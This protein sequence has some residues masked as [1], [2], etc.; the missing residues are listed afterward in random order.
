MPGIVNVVPARRQRAPASPEG[1]REA[2]WR[3]NRRLSRRFRLHSSPLTI[4]SPKRK[5]CRGSTT[6]REVHHNRRGCRSSRYDATPH[7]EAL[8]GRQSAR[9]GSFRRCLD[10]TV[11]IPLEANQEDQGEE[12][13]VPAWRSARSAHEH[14]SELQQISGRPRDRCNCHSSRRI[15]MLARSKALPDSNR[16]RPGRLVLLSLGLPGASSSSLR[17]HVLTRSISFG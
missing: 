4:G 16:P 6:H 3:R 2:A 7:S 5:W 15:D 1:C 13:A 9:C 10:G 12:V 8:P 14:R 17:L 11:H